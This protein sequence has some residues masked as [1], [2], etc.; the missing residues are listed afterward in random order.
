[1]KIETIRNIGNVIWVLYQEKATQLTIEKITL[2]ITRGG[3]Y[4][5][6]RTNYGNDFTAEKSFNSKEELLQSL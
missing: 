4:E 3:E 1:M 6:Y 2:E 5:T